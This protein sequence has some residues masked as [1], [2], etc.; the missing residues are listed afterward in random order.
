[1]ANEVIKLRVL[2]GRD[3]PGLSR[4]APNVIQSIPITE[5]GQGTW[6]DTEKEVI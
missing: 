5:E 6:T 3:Y 1:M 2:K 4:W